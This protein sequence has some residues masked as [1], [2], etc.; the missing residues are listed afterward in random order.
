MKMSQR[1]CDKAMDTLRTPAPG[2]KR[3]AKGW[4]SPER[5]FYEKCPWVSE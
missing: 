5:S 2:I 4:L 1:L 3:Y